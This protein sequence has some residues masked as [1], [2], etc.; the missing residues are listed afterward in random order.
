MVL[1]EKPDAFKSFFKMDWCC[2][3]TNDNEK[4]QQESRPTFGV[5]VHQIYH[6]TATTAGGAP[7][8]MIHQHH[9]AQQQQQQQPI[10]PPGSPHPQY[11]EAPP[12][13][14]FDDSSFRLAPRPT[15]IYV[16]QGN[17]STIDGE[18]SGNP[19]WHQSYLSFAE[20]SLQRVRTM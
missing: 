3:R 15:V 20:E 19:N 18:G 17:P 7:L 9:M 5:P 10:L 1:L 12:S 4:V 14:S 16:I 2:R 11:F 8:Q 13:S 6:T